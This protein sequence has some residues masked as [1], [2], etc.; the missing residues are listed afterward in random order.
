MVFDMI[1]FYCISRYGMRYMAKVMKESLHERFPEAPE[2]D[3]LKVIL[4]TLLFVTIYCLSY[5]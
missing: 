1:I 5:G 4:K 3:V 2:K